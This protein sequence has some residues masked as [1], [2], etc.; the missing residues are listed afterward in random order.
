MTTAHAP[1]N[2]AS[3]HPGP[4]VYEPAWEIARLFPDQG[5]WSEADYLE[6][7]TNRLV[8]LIN[9]N[10]EVPPMPTEAHQDIVIFL[11]GLL[12]AYIRAT[13]AGKVLIAPMHM[14]MPGGNFRDPDVLF[15]KTENAHRR[16]NQFWDGADLVMEVVSDNDRRRDLETKRTEYAQANIPEYWIVDPM[17]KQITVLA[18]NGEQY[19][20]AGVYTPGSQAKSVQLDGFAVDVSATFVAK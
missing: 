5:H 4:A 17:L 14:K 3:K 20:E 18:L 19:D 16:S 1:P 6:L 12:Q 15:M 7:N 8:E 9:G 13:S 11:L 10:I 2:I